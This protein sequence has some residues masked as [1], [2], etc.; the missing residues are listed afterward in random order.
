MPS[1]FHTWSQT[2]SSNATADSAVNWAEGQA[3]SSVNDSSRAE[4][5]V[6]AKWRDDNNGSLTTGGTSTAFTLT[7]NTGFTTLALLANQTLAFTMNATSGATPTLNVDSLGAKVIRTAT[8][9]A[10]PTGALL[11][12][13]VYRVTYNNSSGEFLLHNQ[14]GV[15]ATGSV[16]TAAIAAAAVT[17]AKIQNVAG[18]RLFGNPTGSAAAGSEISLGTG[19]AFSGTTLAATVSPA[20]LPNYLSGLT[21][22]TAGPSSTF[23]IAAGGASDTTNTALMSLASAYTKTTA[24]WAVGSTN[25]GLDTGAIANSTWYHVYLIERTDT[26]VV[27]VL[28]STSAS[29]PTMPTNYTLFRRIG[30]MKTDGSARWTLFTQIGDRFLWSAMVTDVAVVNQ[31]TTAILYP[32]TTPAGIQTIALVRAN[33]ASASG[34]IGVLLSSPSESDQAPTTAT[35]C[36]LINAGAGTRTA[37]EFQIITD[38]SRQVRARGTASSISME[39]DTYGWI[40]TRGKV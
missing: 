2:A 36:S 18:S 14:S 4:M 15:L 5:S 30:A 40:D 32:L 21:L 39:I 11:S 7:T 1:G 24:S 13:S 38:T 28:F 20:L 8:G 34:T 26:G 3:P 31:S 19:L 35:L 9:V 33:A 22:S 12:G 25:G 27:D 37:G 23:T 10:L 17:Y 29:S 16:V 6:L